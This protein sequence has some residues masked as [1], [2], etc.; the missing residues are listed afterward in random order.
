MYRAAIEL[1]IPFHDLDPVNIVWHGNYA[2]YF[3]QARCELLERFNYSY[4]EMRTSGYL[5]PIVDL[6]VRYIK[7][8]IFKQR[9]CVEAIL[10]EWEY[11]LKIDY[12]IT[13]A[14][15]K[16]R[17]TKGSTVQV[18]VDMKTRELCLM[19]PRVLLERLGVQS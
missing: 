4:D 2:K 5:W 3:E 14:V 1:Q 8:L 19:S 6:Q 16:Q 11:R 13:D 7:P 18:A 17:L 10:K 12:L 15:T 9:V